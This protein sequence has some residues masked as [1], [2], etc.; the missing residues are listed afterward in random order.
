[1]AIPNLPSD[2]KKAFENSRLLK[3][4]SDTVIGSKYY[5]EQLYLKIANYVSEFLYPIP[6]LAKE[7]N[8]IYF[9]FIKSYNKDCK[10]FAQTKK[11]PLELDPNR[12]PLARY[13]YD[14][15]LLMSCLL[16]PHRFRIMQ[17]IESLKLKRDTGLIIG[18]GPGL[19]LQL[20]KEKMNSLT[21]YDASLNSVLSNIHPEVIFHKKYFK[22]SSKETKYGAIFLIEL[23][24]HLDDPFEILQ[25]CLKFLSPN[26]RLFLTTATN[27]P[28]FDHLYNFDSDHKMFEKKIKDIGYAIT[29]FE[30]IPHLQLT[31]NIHPSNRFYAL[32]LANK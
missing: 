15:I 14:T 22:K 18:C 11:Y 20:I 9:E 32:T 16:T 31:S 30:D 27:I 29:F 7:P 8:K 1:M 17:I 21:A 4:L 25:T 12:L 28:Q 5:E 3:I 26:G 24:E 2:I 19:E 10:L 6:A 13:E 23:L